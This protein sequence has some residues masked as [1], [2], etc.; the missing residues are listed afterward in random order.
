M[1]AVQEFLKTNTL[2][3]LTEQFGIKVKDYPDDVAFD[4]GRNLD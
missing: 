4:F 2:A 3:D 1:L